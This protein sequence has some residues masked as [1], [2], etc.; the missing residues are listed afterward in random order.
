LSL[1]LASCRAVAAGVE[2]LRLFPTYQAEDQLLSL[3]VAVSCGKLTALIVGGH[4]KK[5]RFCIGGSSAFI[6]LGSAVA[7]A[8]KTGML[9]FRYYVLQ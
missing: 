5:F 3:H 7:A 8:N 2:V 1:Q 6:P 4:Q 9:L